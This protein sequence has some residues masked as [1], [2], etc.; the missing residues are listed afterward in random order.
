MLLLKA[1]LL[2]NGSRR[3]AGELFEGADKVRAVVKAGGGAGVLDADAVV[4]KLFGLGDAALDDIVVERSAGFVFEQPAEIVFV[5]IQGVRHLG[6]LTFPEIALNV[7]N[8]L[9]RP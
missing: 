9:F 4:Q 7:A 2:F 6:G 8:G 1:P 3:H 5:D